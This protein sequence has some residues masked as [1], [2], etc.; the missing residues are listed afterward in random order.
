MPPW[1]SRP[2]TTYGASYG[3]TTTLQVPPGYRTDIGYVLVVCLNAY[4]QNGGTDAMSRV[5][6]TL[7]PQFKDG[8][9]VIAPD[10]LVDSFG[11]KIWYLNDKQ[12]TKSAQ[13]TDF[14]VNGLI[15]SIKADYRVSYVIGVGY[16]NGAA[17]LQEI[18]IGNP[19]VFSAVVAYMGFE[20]TNTTISGPASSRVPSC[21][22]H[23][24][25]DGTVP[26]DGGTLANGDNGGMTF[27]GALAAIADMH[28]ANGG[29]N[30]QPLDPI[31]SSIHLNSGYAG[32]ESDVQDY[33]DTLD[34][35][36]TCNGVGHTLGVVTGFAGR[37]MA[38]W[39][40]DHH[41]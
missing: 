24:T 11:N 3:R 29:S 37:Y 17:K 19:G 33:P 28:L 31:S 40:I 18:A 10:G 16:S 7:A 13:D 39:A 22:I 30:A 38:R 26:Y 12:P 21:H 41:R 25:A 6:F 36:I 15:A 8:F 5:D 2:P 4:S 32:N 27:K 20:S 1:I 23:G 34:R 35:M 14:L 9:L